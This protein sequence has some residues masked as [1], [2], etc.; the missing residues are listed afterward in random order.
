MELVVSISWSKPMCIDQVRKEV[1]ILSSKVADERLQ[2]STSRLIHSKTKRKRKASQKWQN[3]PVTEYT[4]YQTTS[5]GISTPKRSQEM[6]K[7]FRLIITVGHSSAPAKHRSVTNLEALH[8]A[9][10]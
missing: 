9:Y 1:L 7:K 10:P 4:A 6:R 2:A 8:M 3:V 5:F